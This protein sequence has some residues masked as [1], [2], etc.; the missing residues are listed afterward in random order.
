MAEGNKRR[1]EEMGYNGHIIY[2]RLTWKGAGHMAGGEWMMRWGRDHVDGERGDG[3]MS[4]DEEGLKG[5]SL[6]ARSGGE[7]V[8]G[9]RTIQKV[10]RQEGGPTS[11]PHHSGPPPPLIKGRMAKGGPELLES[12]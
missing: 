2:G 1:G 7:Q 8:A 9:G 5:T 11:I 3:Q 4:E 6:V 12:R 10:T